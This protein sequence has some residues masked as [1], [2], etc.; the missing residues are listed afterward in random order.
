MQQHDHRLMHE[1]PLAWGEGGCGGG[2]VAGDGGRQEWALSRSERDAGW[3]T[4]LHVYTA[5]LSEQ[6]E[7]C[8]LRLGR[9]HE[10]L[11]L[12]DQT[13]PFGTAQ[14]GTDVAVLLVPNAEVSPQ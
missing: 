12:R 5:R 1:P 14:D 10:L 3:F 6:Q 8:L 13:G 2:R 4:F 11:E 7:R 9:G